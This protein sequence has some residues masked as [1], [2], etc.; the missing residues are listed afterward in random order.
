[1][2]ILFWPMFVS[3]GDDSLFLFQIDFGDVVRSRS[4]TDGDSDVVVVQALNLDPRIYV[5]LDLKSGPIQIVIKR[6]LW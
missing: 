2:P 3:W 6:I 4:H 5:K 1:M